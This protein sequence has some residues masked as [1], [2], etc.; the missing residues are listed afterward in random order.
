MN[1]IDFPNGAVFWHIDWIIDFT[2]SSYFSLI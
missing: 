1:Y 2:K